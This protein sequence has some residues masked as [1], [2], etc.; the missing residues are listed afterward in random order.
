MEAGTPAV[1]HD[2][3]AT[4]SQLLQLAPDQH[5]VRAERRQLVRGAA[6][7]AG[8]AAGDENDLAGEQ[9]RAEDGAVGRHRRKGRAVNQAL[10]W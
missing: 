1:G 8:A 2:L 6:A 9:A 7:D 3:A 4:V 10:A 5:H